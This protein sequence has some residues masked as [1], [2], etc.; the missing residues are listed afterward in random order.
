[1]VVN[2]CL[3][4]GSKRHLVSY[5]ERS[6]TVVQRPMPKQAA[7]TA[8][9]TSDDHLYTKWY[10]GGNA[11]GVNLAEHLLDEAWLPMATVL[12]AL[13][14]KFA[15]NARRYL[16]ED[17]DCPR[18]RWTFARQ[19]NVGLEGRD[20]KVAV[21]KKCGGGK[22]GGPYVVKD[23]FLKKVTLARYRH[24]LTPLG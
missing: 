20:W 17:S 13:G 15:N 14:E 24:R 6:A 21:S 4:C 18:K 5:H 9:V 1:M 19:S 16:C 2:A 3:V 23:A 8:A 22:K 7:R 12:A 11:L 10:G